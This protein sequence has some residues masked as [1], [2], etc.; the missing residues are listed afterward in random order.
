MGLLSAHSLRTRGF[1]STINYSHE[2]AEG[3]RRQ[4]AMEGEN[5]VHFESVSMFLRYHIVLALLG[6]NTSLAKSPYSTH[7]SFVY[8][9]L[10]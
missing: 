2:S 3:A 8:T 1:R 5:C 4:A 10:L 7:V 9:C 6:A